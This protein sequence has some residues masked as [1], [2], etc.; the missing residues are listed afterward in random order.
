MRSRRLFVLLVLV[1]IAVAWFAFGRRM[2]F[3]RSGQ[4]SDVVPV[5]DAPAPAATADGERGETPDA[6][7]PR[8]TLAIGADPAGVGAVRVRLLAWR[9][10]KPIV[11]QAVRLVPASGAPVERA[12]GEDG[13]VLFPEVASGEWTLKVDAAPFPPVE[14]K[15]VVVRARR[16]TDLDD[17]LLGEKVVLR[18]RV[19]DGKGAPVPGAAV[20]AFSGA[21]FD[22]SQGVLLAMVEDALAFP[23]PVDEARSDERGQFALSALTPGTYRLSTRRPGYA[24]DVK[25]DLVVSPDRAAG[26]LTIVLGPPGVVRGKVVDERDAPIAGAT[27][28]AVEDLGPRGL[29]Q[30]TLRKDYAVTGADGRYVLD[31]LVRGT[32]YRL[33]VVA[34][35]RAPSFD[36]QGTVV[37]AE[38]E[39]DFTLALGGTLS[40]TVTDSATGKPLA[41]ARVVAIVG[42]VGGPM[43]RGPRAGRGGAGGAAP[44]GGT[45]DTV[46]ATQVGTTG[47]DGTYRL[48]GL[49]PGTIAFFQVRAAGYAQPP[50]PNPFFGTPPAYGDV[51]AGETTTLD[52][53]LDPGGVVTGRV[54]VAGPDGATGVP[55][56]QVAIVSIAGPFPDV[57]GGYPTGITDAE[58]VYRVDGVRAGATFGVVAS[59]PGL[60]ASSAMDAANQGAMPA[61]AGEVVKDVTLSAAGAVEG[62]V[63]T[64]KGVPVAGARLRVRPRPQGGGFGGGGWW[65]MLFPGGGGG[66]ALSDAEGRYR[67]EDVASTDRIAIEAESDEHVPSESEP[68]VVAAGET[69][70]VDLVLL[71]GGTI[72]GRVIDDQGKVVAGASVRV[73]RLDEAGEA[74]RELSGWAADRLLE[75]RIVFTDERGAFEVVRVRPGRTLLKVEKGGFVTSYRRD[76]S[77]AADQVL[78]GHVVALTRGESISGVVRG[79]DG[80]PLARVDVAATKQATPGL[81]F[82]RGAAPAAPAADSPPDPTVEPLLSGRTDEQGRFTIEAVPPGTSYSVVVW[83]APGHL[84]WMQGHEGAIRRGV[85]PG[86]RDVELRLTKADPSAAGPGFPMPT[87]TRPPPPAPAPP[88]APGMR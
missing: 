29:G 20:S 40:G 76:L 79:E 62:T 45:T 43:S 51:R 53:K 26:L 59:A 87:G 30:T 50:G 35:D 83:R 68:F 15:G 1:A 32:S 72:R 54:L 75:P 21:G 84:G 14:V 5:D 86:T 22:F 66:T 9:T 33:G 49:R 2:V 39:R 41:G 10:R 64:S 4:Q 23:V 16:T 48:E 55:G 57:M 13:R 6:E 19:V 74:A 61:E 60:V 67:I 17:L 46:A 37:E 24:M 42:Q 77:V 56:A 58:G 47:A 25:T 52:A 71:G 27:V 18:G 36:T 38:T 11:R 73:G 3:P 70:R 44:G 63:A 28:L 81:G 69:Q 31:T 85:A 88:P 82:G 78:E 12:T 34:K 8:P 65:R 80:R 7:A